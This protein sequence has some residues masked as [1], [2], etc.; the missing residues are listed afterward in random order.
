MSI[1]PVLIGSGKDSQAAQAIVKLH[2]SQRSSVTVIISP[3][4]PSPIGNLLVASPIE[5]IKSQTSVHL[6]APPENPR[7]LFRKPEH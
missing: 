7:A 4:P 6:E 3:S 2:Q 5:G 1:K